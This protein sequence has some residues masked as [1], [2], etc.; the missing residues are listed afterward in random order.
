MRFKIFNRKIERKNIRNNKK[1]CKKHVIKWAKE[2]ES[3]IHKHVAAI[4]SILFHSIICTNCTLYTHI[5]EIRACRNRSMGGKCYMKYTN[6]HC[7]LSNILIPAIHLKLTLSFYVCW[8]IVL[9]VVGCSCVLPLLP[10][11]LPSPLPPPL[12]LLLL[13]PVPVAIIIVHFS[14]ERKKN[15]EI[16]YLVFT[17]KRCSRN[18]MLLL[19]LLSFSVWAG[20]ALHIQC[21]WL[22]D[23]KTLWQH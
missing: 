9:I 22:Y 19:L 11:L 18:S 17:F 5:S 21:I 14:S 3:C 1:K 13:L 15:T 2:I 20:Y 12:M 23:G 6:T 4:V 8:Y 10:L 7:T 16:P